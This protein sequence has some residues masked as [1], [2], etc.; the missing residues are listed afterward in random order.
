VSPKNVTPPKQNQ[1]SQPSVVSEK[2]EPEEELDIQDVKVVK[3]GS[4]ITIDLKLVNNDPNG[5][6]LGGFV[7]MLAIAGNVNPPQV[8]VYPRQELENGLPMDFR[9]GELFIMK[10]FRSIQGKIYL[11][12]DGEAPSNVKVLVY[13]QSG[14]IMIEKV[15]EVPDES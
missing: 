12:P 9:R 2:R 13:D 3:E 14:E 4:Q 5:K 10:S 15:F 1:R 8:W 11:V 7:H 6:R